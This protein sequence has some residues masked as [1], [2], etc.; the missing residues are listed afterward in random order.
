M[1]LEE[2]Y[3]LKPIE[4]LKTLSTKRLLAYYVAER[5]KYHNTCFFCSCCGTP[6]WKLGEEYKEKEYKEWV[7]RLEN[8]RRILNTREHVVK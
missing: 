4:F 5:K 3:K 8:I 6:M 2:K 7:E 1:S